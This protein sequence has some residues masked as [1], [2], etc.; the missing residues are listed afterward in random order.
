[1]EVGSA[2]RPL[3]GEIWLPGDKSISHRA[4]ILAAIARG[5]SII[6]NYAPG[7]DCQSTLSCL[8]ALGVA[9]DQVSDG[10]FAITGCGL[11]GFKEPED[12]LDCGN[13]G[14][15]MRLLAGI[16][17]GQGFSSILTGDSSLRKRPMAR[18]VDPLRHMGASIVGRQGGR[19]AP[20]AIRGGSLIGMSHTIPVASA[21]VKSALLLAGLWASGETWVEEPGLSR[22]HT[23]RLL[24]AFGGEVLRS[25]GDEGDNEGDNAGRI[26]AS[27]DTNMVGVRGGMVLSGREFIVPGDISSAAFFIVGACLV[28]GSHLV[29]R[30]VGINPTRT[31]ILDVLQDMGAEISVMPRSGSGAPGAG[32]IDQP[33]LELKPEPEPGAGPA[34]GSYEPAGDI[35]VRYSGLC[36]TEIR[37][38]IMP[39]LIDEIPI[40]AVAATQAEGTTIIRD[41][42]ELRVKESDRLKG[43]AAGLRA[44]GANVE[45]L[46]DGLVIPGP[47]RLRGARVQSLGDHRLAMAFS[48]A[49]LI[50]DGITTV[51]DAAC[52]SISFPGFYDI[53]RDLQPQAGSARGDRGEG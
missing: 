23:E 11:D 34:A 49:G 8:R 1:M 9:I 20:L 36:A 19:F 25:E 6:R 7:A 42:A 46:P 43:L 38:D 39:R 50:A 37:G 29:L 32:V 27:C 13:S 15:T 40:I 14:T 22:D 2:G 10:T 4:A 45:E 51:E 24:E 26:R 3:R 41:A 18:V 30:D 52:V 53:L 44:M 5:Q 33:E 35:E 48:I 16:L 47:A 31:G 12:V 17:A 21:Q 28:P